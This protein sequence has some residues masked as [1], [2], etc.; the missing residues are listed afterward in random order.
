M[1]DRINMYLSDIFTVN[2]NLAGLPGMSFPAGMLDG[3]PVGAQLTGNYFEE[4]KL[5]NVAH[6]YQQITDWHTKIPTEFL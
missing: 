6:Q 3:L 5:L 4:V 2:T 1:K